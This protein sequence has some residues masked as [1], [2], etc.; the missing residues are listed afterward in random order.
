MKKIIASTMILIAFTLSA[1]GTA[2]TN[3]PSAQIEPGNGELPEITKLVIGTLN[4]K[5]TENAVTPE[6]AQELLP[7]WRVYLSLLS[8]DTAAQEEIDGLVEQIKETMTS[9]QLQAITDM[10]LTQR[11][12]FTLMEEKGLGMGGT[13]RNNSS[14][15]N[16]TGNGNNFPG[17]GFGGPPDGFVPPDGGFQGGPG[18][19]G[20]NL[21]PEQIATAQAARQQGGRG[22]GAFMPTA[23]LDALI[24]LLQE[25]P[26][27]NGEALV[28]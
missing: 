25:K 23:L 6:Q 16:N 14:G 8:S 5:E 13:Q 1:C 9:E 10:N 12:I 11:D 4:L 2:Q 28:Y 21:N 19:G 7:L 27:R 18:G 20:Q 24:K 22:G 3:T 26:A 17:G 15:G